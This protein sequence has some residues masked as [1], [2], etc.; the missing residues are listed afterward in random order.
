M[1]AGQI[2]VSFALGFATLGC[3]V[4]VGQDTSKHASNNPKSAILKPSEVNPVTPEMA[5][6]ASADSG[7]KAPDFSLKGTDGKSYTLA[8]L[9][10]SGPVL[11]YFINLDCP[12]CVSAQPFVEELAKSLPKPAHVLG[13]INTDQEKAAK[14]LTAN[15]ASYVA[16]LDPDSRMITDYR[17]KAGTYMAILGTDGTMVKLIP[18]YSKVL[19]KEAGKTMAQLTGAAEYNP[20]AFSAAPDTETSGCRF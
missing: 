20:P 7:R 16:L 1:R 11:L 13:V 4:E 12:C 18:G 8:S 9:T 14:W 10:Q 19:L 3:N 5:S 17:A 15:K 2:F 6:Q